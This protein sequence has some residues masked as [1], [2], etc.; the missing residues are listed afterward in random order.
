MKGTRERSIY[1]VVL[2][3]VLAL[4]LSRGFML[5]VRKN[6]EAEGK[7]LIIRIQRD[8]LNKGTC[9][10]R[11]GVGQDENFVPRTAPQCAGP[12]AGNGAGDHLGGPTGICGAPLFFAGT[13]PISGALAASPFFAG[14][15]LGPHNFKS[16]S[17]RQCKF[18]AYVKQ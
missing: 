11:F 12:Q 9:S 17:R 14:H 8:D 18:L 15:R 3:G 6:R 16:I 4:Q 2:H 13:R 7:G 10:V 5:H 1:G